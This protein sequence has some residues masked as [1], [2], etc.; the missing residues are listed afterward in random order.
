MNALAFDFDDVIADFNGGYVNFHNRTFGTP[1]VSFDDIT[2]FDMTKIYGVEHD[3]I[4]ARVMKFCHEHHDEIEPWADAE[5]CLRRLSEKYE[6][7]IVTS[8]CETLRDTTEGWLSEHN[9]RDYITELHFTN[10]FG[11]KFPKR[12]RTKE[13]VCQ[14]IGA[15]A[16]IE[17]APT[18]ALSVAKSGTPVC[19]PHRPWNG[20]VWHHR[21]LR[22]W[23]LNTI[24]F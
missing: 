16:L 14:E 7:H 18:H 4:V 8:R 13:R 11:S 9:L 19:L 2:D 1:T 20:N 17:D 3:T 5:P 24:P 23:D 15:T 22:V 10:G 21:V 6:L 12:K